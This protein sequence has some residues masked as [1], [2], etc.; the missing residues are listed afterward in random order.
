MSLPGDLYLV[1]SQNSRNGLRDPNTRWKFPIPYI[2]A[3]NL[4]NTNCSLLGALD[5][6]LLPPP[7][8]VHPHQ[9]G[10]NQSCVRG[11]LSPANSYLL[12]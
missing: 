8:P 2:L 1:F 6:P 3:D 4:G 5:L 10:G 7:P 11:F 12:A 9:M